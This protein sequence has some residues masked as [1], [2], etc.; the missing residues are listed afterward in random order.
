MLH[1]SPNRPGPELFDAVEAALISEA[2][3]ALSAHAPGDAALLSKQILQLQVLNQTLYDSPS[4]S[5]AQNLGGEQ[6][7]PQGL[8]AHLTRTDGLAGDLDLPIKAVLQRTY[9]LA[10][11]QL[12]RAFV[13]SIGALSK[14][15]PD[16][17]ALAEGIREELAQ[18]IYTQMAEDLLLALL[19][20]PSVE[21]PTKRRAAR[22]LIQI[23]DNAMVEIDDFCPLLES[24]WHARNRVHPGLG[25]LLG[26]TEY[27]RLVAEDCS[28]DFLDFFA[29]D[30]VSEAENQA[31]AEFLFGLTWE[32]LET[33]R[34]EMK[35]QKI[36]VADEQ[37]AAKVLGREIE[38]DCDDRLTIDPIALYRSYTRRQLAAD[39]RILAGKAGPRR[40]AEAYLMIYLLNNESDLATIVG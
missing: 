17:I 5:A 4:L 6:R 26:T 40:T 9:L 1:E 13:K 15:E 8:V 3:V 35:R 33:L 29:R 39:Y 7:S 31:F 20:K 14:V 11:I 2:M 16:H 21:I 10:K 27:F 38:H 30:G 32:E 25:C 34:S 19:R 18:S 12:L 28:D 36:E 37:W 23:W 22:Q 24:A